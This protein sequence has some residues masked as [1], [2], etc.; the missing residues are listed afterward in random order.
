MTQ[1]VAILVFDGVDIVDSG[2]PYEVFLT[3]SRLAVRDGLDPL[4][5]V[6]LVSPGGQDITAFGG[7]RLTALAD[8]GAVGSVDIAVIPG[9]IDVSTALE[10]EPLREAVSALLRNAQVTASVC[11]GAFLLADAGALGTHAATT[12][13]ED[14]T[15]LANT[16]K[17]AEAVVGVRWVDEGA[18][19]TSAGLTSGMHMALHLIA[20]RHGE[21]LAART[22]KQLDLDWDPRGQYRAPH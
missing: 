12:H 11:T 18:I 21:E 7:M 14:V 3:A 17:V 9:T 1:R 13:W 6:V 15:E 16:G 4:Y 8:A 2:G 20:K 10:S 5:D 22:A 19:V